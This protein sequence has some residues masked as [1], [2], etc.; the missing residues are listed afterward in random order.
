MNALVGIGVYTPAE[1]ERL[2]DVPA[3]KITRW[4]RGHSVQGQ[5]YAPLWMPQVD[6]GDGRVYLGFR[7]LMEVR[8]ADAWI[9]KGISAIRVRAAI[10][11]AREVYGLERPL[12]TDAFKTNGRDIFMKV[13]E[14]D[15][16]GVERE[17]LLNTFRKQYVFSS[18]MEPLLRNIDFDASG[19]PE[20]WW[21]KGRNGQIVVDPKRSFGQPIDA[22][23][24]VPTAILAAAAKLQ[25]IDL[26]A[27]A[28]DVPASSVRRAVKFESGRETRLA[29]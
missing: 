18:I 24:S 22:V 12:S 21:P 6:I 16:D 5:D 19:V 20:I 27:K 29:A 9:A 2:V 7:D 11:L 3:G 14:R 28:Y 25:G 15:S 4:L 17:R 26:A 1:A 8:V 23:S 13:T 10:E